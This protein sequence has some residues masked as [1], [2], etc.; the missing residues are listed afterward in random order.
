[1]ALETILIVISS[2]LGVVAAVFGGK[3]LVAKGKLGQFLS[4]GK[5][6]MDVISACVD[7]LEDTG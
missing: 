4:L 5:E 3:F 1:M 6:G 2:L 7:A